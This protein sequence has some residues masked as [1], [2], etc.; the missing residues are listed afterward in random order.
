MPEYPD[1]EVYVR[2][3][4]THV[5]DCVIEEARI[6]SPFVVRTYDPP[7]SEVPGKRIL[8]VERLGK[9]IVFGLEDDLHLVIHLMISGRLR[10]KPRGLKLARRLGLAAFDFADGSLSFT[11][12]GTKKRASIHLVRGRLPWPNS[13]E[14]ASKCSRLRSGTSTTACGV[15]IT[16]SSGP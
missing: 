3:L 14:V 15:K 6:A 9:R 10:W 7:M 8:T 11:E 1:V 16:P 12:A 5:V 13:I 4:R 2:R